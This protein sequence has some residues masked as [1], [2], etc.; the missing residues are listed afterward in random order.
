MTMLRFFFWVL[1]CWVIGITLNW[2]FA[3]NSMQGIILSAVP[4]ILLGFQTRPLFRKHAR[5]VI[6]M[7]LYANQAR[8]EQLAFWGIPIGGPKE[9]RHD[10]S[11]VLGAIPRYDEYRKPRFMPVVLK[12]VLF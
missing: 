3:S 9:V 12:K 8:Y 2:A 10:L 4:F 1:I 7:P 5:S 11:A 6:G